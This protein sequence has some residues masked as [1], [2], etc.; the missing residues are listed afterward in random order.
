MQLV[1][2]Y[3]RLVLMAIGMDAGGGDSGGGGLAGPV[4]QTECCHGPC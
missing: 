2:V 3:D 1:M 4:R